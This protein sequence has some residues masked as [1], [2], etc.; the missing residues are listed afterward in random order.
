MHMVCSLYYDSFPKIIIIKKIKQLQC[1]AIYEIKMPV[2][3][4]VNTQ[5][6]YLPVL[7]RSLIGTGFCHCP[8][9]LCGW[10][11]C[12]WS[13]KDKQGVNVQQS[14]ALDWWSIRHNDECS[15]ARNLSLE[16]QPLAAAKDSS[17]SV[18]Y[19]GYRAPPCNSVVSDT[20]KI[21]FGESH[22]EIQRKWEGNYLM[23]VNCME[24]HLCWGEF[25]VQC[26]APHARVTV[27]HTEKETIL[28]KT[29]NKPLWFIISTCHSV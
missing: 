18:L 28:T 13:W 1:T 11:L 9:L 27:S 29:D 12:W 23:Q 22:F 21:H 19:I 3:W 24:T 10:E 4:S 16:Y 7:C 2:L 14:R 5:S 17:L 15:S 25:W 20:Q 8:K 26:I 6:Y